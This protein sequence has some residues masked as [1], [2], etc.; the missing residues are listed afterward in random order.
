VYLSSYDR[1]TKRLRFSYAVVQ[2]GAAADGGDLYVV[3]DP[4]QYTAGLA[5]AV[6]ITSGGGICG[7]AGSTC[8][9]DQLI[10][11]TGAGLFA[12]VAID[13]DGNLKIVVEKAAGAK[14]ADTQAWPSASPSATTSPS[15]S[16]GG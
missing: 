8:T 10:A 15:Q 6:Q 3:D 14:L 4:A 16:A 5:S 9:P 12:E 11:A 2:R 13:A 1:D 7:P